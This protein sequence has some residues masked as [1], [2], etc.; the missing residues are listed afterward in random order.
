MASASNPAA[1]S[2]L[3]SHPLSPCPTPAPLPLPHFYL[4]SVTC[5]LR[6]HFFPKQL[7][8]LIHL[9]SELPPTSRVAYNCPTDNA[10]YFR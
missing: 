4:V 7:E 2:G 9:A 5:P 3:A 6:T 10:L 8:G 1:S